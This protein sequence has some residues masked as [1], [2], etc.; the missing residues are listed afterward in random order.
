MATLVCSGKDLGY[1]IL[2]Y[3]RQF[4]ESI[5]QQLLTHPNDHVLGYITNNLETGEHK[6]TYTESGRFVPD[7]EHWSLS[8]MKEFP[9]CEENGPWIVYTCSPEKTQ[10]EFGKILYNSSETLHIYDWDTWSIVEKNAKVAVI[11][12]WEIF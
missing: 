6:F 4:D 12:S 3:S 1:T 7:N 11:T 8:I 5:E 9:Y 2:P 10:L